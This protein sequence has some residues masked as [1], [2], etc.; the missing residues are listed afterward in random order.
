MSASTR[1]A[2]IFIPADDGE[3][4]LEGL[5]GPDAPAIVSI[6]DATRLKPNGQASPEVIVVDE[7]QAADRAQEIGALI[8]EGSSVYAAIHQGGGKASE[9]QGLLKDLAQ[10]L[11]IV[12]DDCP[13]SRSDNPI[14]NSLKA[15]ALAVKENDEEAYQ[16]GRSAFVEACGVDWNLE[17]RLAL[18]HGCLVPRD[19]DTQVPLPKA[20]SLKHVLVL[21]GFMQ[22]EEA[23]NLSLRSNVW[24]GSDRRQIRETAIALR[25]PGAYG[26]SSQTYTDEYLEQLT[27]LR[28]RLLSD[29]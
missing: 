11:N 5:F 1:I 3:V 27:D 21:D 24:G 29:R 12:Y 8:L 9:I 10:E 22:E 18:L 19:T 20:P 7:A 28:D 16:A 17:A 4:S 15:I 6:H 23:T 14:T 26:A 25:T 13:F 2:L